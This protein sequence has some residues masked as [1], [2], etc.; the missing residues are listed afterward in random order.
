LAQIQQKASLQLIQFRQKWWVENL[1]KC[2]E[3]RGQCLRWPV[4]ALIEQHGF[5]HGLDQVEWFWQSSADMQQLETQIRNAVDSDEVVNF[6]DLPIFSVNN[7][8]HTG[9]KMIFHASKGINI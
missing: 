2:T 4:R 9:V 1:I 3:H 5:T 8:V 7:S 6:R